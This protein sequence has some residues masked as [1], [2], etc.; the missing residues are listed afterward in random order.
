MHRRA[1]KRAAQ[2]GISFAE[3][4]R[5]LVA[6]DLDEPPPRRDPVVLFNLGTSREADVAQRKDAMVGD[7]VAAGH[8]RDREKP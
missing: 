2:L 4:I 3:Y 5:R 1:I 8:G 6:R 7:A